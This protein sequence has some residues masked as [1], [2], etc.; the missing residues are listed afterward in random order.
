MT[1]SEA[2]VSRVLVEL[3]TSQE[4]WVK[5]NACGLLCITAV[6]KLFARKARRDR[7][8]RGGENTVGSRSSS[9]NVANP[10]APC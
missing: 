2:G 3:G 7:I 1:R 10:F 8:K 5:R 6:T 4:G 9:I